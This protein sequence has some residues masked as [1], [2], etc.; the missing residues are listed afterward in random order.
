MVAQPTTVMQCQDC[1]TEVDT[2][3]PADMQEHAGHNLVKIEQ[4]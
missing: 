3:N 4:G 1:G 2:A